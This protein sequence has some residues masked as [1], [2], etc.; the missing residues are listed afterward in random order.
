MDHPVVVI[1]ALIALSGLYI[2]APV[3]LHA[4]MSY[5]KTRTVICP[6]DNRPADIMLDAQHAAISALAGKEHLKIRQCS[7][8]PRKHG[9]AQG[10]VRYTLAAR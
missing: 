4:F 6:E 10:C 7:L 9:C 8:W 3:A 5:R 2:I 1:A